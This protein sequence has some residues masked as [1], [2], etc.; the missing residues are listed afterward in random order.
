MKE[1]QLTVE[2]MMAIYISKGQQS[3]ASQNSSGERNWDALIDQP[4]TRITQF[5]LFLTWIGDWLVMHALLTHG[6]TGK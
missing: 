2:E 4:G 6:S 1:L 3:Q 5:P